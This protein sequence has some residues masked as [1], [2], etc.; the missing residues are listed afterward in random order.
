[1]KKKCVTFY[2][3][4]MLILVLFFG[5]REIFFDVNAMFCRRYVGVIMI[6]LIGVIVMTA[7]VFFFKNIKVHSLAL[8]FIILWGVVIGM[9]MPPGIAP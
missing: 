5:V 3:S 6:L 8:I 9:L 4:I 1:M 2:I 7:V